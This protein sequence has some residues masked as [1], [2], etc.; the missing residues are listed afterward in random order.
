MRVAPKERAK[1]NFIGNNNRIGELRVIKYNKNL[2]QYSKELRNNMTKHEKRLWYDFFKKLP[3][4]VKRQQIIGNYIVDFFIPAK[5]VVIEIDGVQHTMEKNE[6]S[7]IKRDEY[8]LSMGITV[9]R[10]SNESIDNDFITVCVD[11][12]NCLDISVNDLK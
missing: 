7:D 11:I 10:Y 3:F 2:R 5:N 1:S 8:L 9:L 12:L 4:N 6:S